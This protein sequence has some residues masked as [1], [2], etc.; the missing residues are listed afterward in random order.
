MLPELISKEEY[1]LHQY[2]FCL[3]AIAGSWRKTTAH[4]SRRTIHGAG[5]QVVEVQ[6]DVVNRPL[7]RQKAPVPCK[8]RQMH[9]LGLPAAM[10]ARSP[11]IH[12]A[13]GPI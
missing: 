3:G 4:G 7:L 6:R 5:R 13:A 10:H 9:S 11:W 12:K 2:F 1:V 8:R